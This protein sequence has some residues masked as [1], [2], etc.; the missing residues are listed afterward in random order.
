MAKEL[1]PDRPLEREVPGRPSPSFL[2]DRGSK[3][4]SVG[5][6]SGATLA[7]RSRGGEIFVA[8]RAASRFSGLAPALDSA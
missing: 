3:H 8:F 7:E 1:G 2:G 4:P 5:E 6:A